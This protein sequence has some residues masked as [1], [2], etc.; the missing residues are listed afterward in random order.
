[1]SKII[2]HI[3]LNEFFARAEEIRK[4][5]L[6]GKPLAIG[7]DGRG[8]IVSTAS[9]KAREYGIHSGMPMFQAKMLCKEL[10]IIPCDFAYYEL[11]SREFI[12]YIKQFTNIIEQVS[13]DECYADMTEVYKI[14]GKGKID[15]FLKKIQM[16]LYNK[17]K[18]MC[19]IGVAP[20]KFLAKMGSDMKKPMGITII[21]KR[22]IPYLVFPLRVKEFYG[23]GKKTY[24]RLEE[25]G[26]KT[27]G[28]L[29]YSVINK[30]KK[31]EDVLGKFYYQIKELLEGNSSDE[32]NTEKFDPK[33]IGTTRTFNM[34]TNDVSYIKNFLIEEC[35]RILIQL[36][37]A[38]K[39]TKTIQITYKDANLDNNFK[40]KTVSKTFKEYTNNDTFILKEVELLFNK[41]YERNV[42]RLI[43]ISLQNLI[44]KGTTI[45]QMTFDNYLELS[46]NDPVFDL[47]DKLNREADGNVFFRASELKERNRWKK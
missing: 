26:I 38:N 10:I 32:V 7:G 25:I 3:D 29:Y 16:G 24:P 14:Y 17:T 12:F 2:L 20:T 36:H 27:I 1:M 33:S 28:D 19:S 47:L 9:Y 42:I 4:P 11:L 30:E 44:D 39:L 35:K 41:T 5:S 23:I 21:R 22:D 45:T 31:V 43:G 37:N 46:K 13:I 18:L 34:D 40:T 8:G 6:C 15:L